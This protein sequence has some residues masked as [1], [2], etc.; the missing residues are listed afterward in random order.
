LIVLVF[1]GMAQDF[2][3]IVG[4]KMLSSDTVIAKNQI[5]IT[6][7]AFGATTQTNSEDTTLATQAYVDAGG[8]LGVSVLS[9]DKGTGIGSI[10]TAT[11][12]VDTASFEGRWGFLTSDTLIVRND[13]LVLGNGVGVP[14]SEIIIDSVNNAYDA[15]TGLLTTSWYIGASQIGSTVESL[16]GRNVKY[17]DSTD[18]YYTQN[19]LDSALLLAGTKNVFPITLPVAGSLTVSINAAVEGVDYPTGW[20]LTASGGNLQINHG[21]ARY[22]ASVRVKYNVSGDQYRHLKDFE[23]GYSGL[24][25][26]DDNN[27]TIE[28]ITTF[29]NSNKLK[30]YILFE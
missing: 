7:D 5:I 11:I 20:I 14:L 29:Y 16:D 6:G 1:A 26:V 4:L 2:E 17:S 24:L 13:S 15:S 21:L 10:S 18:V 9:F 27:L 22:S 8:A 3:G 28:S 30:I 25:D 12:L 19:Y 23:S